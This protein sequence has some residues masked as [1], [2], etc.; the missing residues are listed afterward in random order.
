MKK[1]KV[2]DKM[3]DSVSVQ[4]NL[5]IPRVLE[6]FL[7]QKIIEVLKQKPYTLPRNADFRFDW[8]LNM[9]TPEDSRLT[10]AV[11]NNKVVEE[12][13]TCTYGYK[14]WTIAFLEML[15][16]FYTYSVFEAHWE[17]K[18]GKVAQKNLSNVL[19]YAYFVDR[20]NKPGFKAG[21]MLSVSGYDVM[22]DISLCTLAY[23]LLT[24]YHIWMEECTT[25][26]W[27]KEVSQPGFQQD[28]VK[29]LDCFGN[30]A[31]RTDEPIA[32][33]ETMFSMVDYLE[34]NALYEA[35]KKRREE[36]YHGN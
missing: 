9:E 35:W 23:R 11:L 5:S 31:I 10:I 29:V 14:V 17:S 4:V 30:I 18:S 7:K 24:K 32:N 33:R 2:I 13:F 21:S 1:Y 20:N 34:D 26:G 25:Q 27:F 19:G 28:V 6:F 36:I 3:V 15:Y 12:E 8:K 16:L 22:E